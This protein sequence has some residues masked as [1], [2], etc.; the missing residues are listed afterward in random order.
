MNSQSFIFREQELN[1]LQSAVDNIT[2]S[3]PSCFFISGSLGIGKTT[4]VENVKIPKT[5]NKITTS[6]FDLGLPAYSVLNNF[7][8]QVK[9]H[10]QNTN[11]DINLK[12]DLLSCFNH[13]LPTWENR[14]ILI[15]AFTEVLET[16]SSLRPL[17]WIIDN[18]HWADLTSLEI[19]GKVL[20]RI[21]HSR[22]VVIACYQDDNLSSE[23]SLCKLRTNYETCLISAK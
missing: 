5:I 12:S 2:V 3:I 1:I 20:R 9:S 19:L 13:E 6:V 17:V 7:I 11:Q 16:A 15:K 10:F 21:N 8:D 14:E 23:L 18:L 4:L 22:V